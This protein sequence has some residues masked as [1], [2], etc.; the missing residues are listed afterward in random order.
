MAR[1]P[2][3]ITIEDD[4]GTPH[5]YEFTPCPALLSVGVV[6][7]LQTILLAPLTAIIAGS[8]Q[9]KQGGSLLD[10]ELDAGA[11]SAAATALSRAVIEA[12][13]AEFVKVLLSYAHTRRAGETALTKCSTN[14]DLLYTQNLGEMALAVYHA[15]QCS[16][17]KS[18]RRFFKGQPIFR[19]MLSAASG[20]AD[21]IQQKTEQPQNNSATSS[22]PQV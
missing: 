3:R 20:L 6:N 15:V 11:A 9:T 2:L 10:R 7:K 5:E 8:R 4:D 12:G 18:L 1:E 19:E 14:I 17:G 22:T 16:F 21:S 13:E